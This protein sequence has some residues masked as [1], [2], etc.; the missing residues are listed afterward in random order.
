LSV[1]KTAAASPPNFATVVGYSRNLLTSSARVIPINIEQ[2]RVAISSKDI[3][4]L[5]VLGVLRTEETVKNILT[6]IVGLN[7]GGTTIKTFVIS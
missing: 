4:L 5:N 2:V 7:A 3:W 1:S 6:H